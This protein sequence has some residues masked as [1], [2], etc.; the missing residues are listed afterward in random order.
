MLWQLRVSLGQ[1]RPVSCQV[2]QL[3]TCWPIP[4]WGRPAGA[5]AQGWS[6][7]PGCHRQSYSDI[8]SDKPRSVFTLL[9]IDIHSYLQFVLNWLHCVVMGGGGA[10]DCCN[11]F[12]LRADLFTFAAWSC[13]QQMYPHYFLPYIFPTRYYLYPKAH[14]I[15]SKKVN[16]KLINNNQITSHQL[17]C[18]T[19][20]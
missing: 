16:F 15:I 19:F 7:C 17:I 18:W 12:S 8:N 1:V 6:S 4:S 20:A 9:S 11:I 13:N 14:L 10:P 3:L 5:E 2:R